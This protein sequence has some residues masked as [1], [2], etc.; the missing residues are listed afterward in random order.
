MNPIV[1]SSLDKTLL[2]ATNLQYLIAFTLAAAKKTAE[3]NTPPAN[4]G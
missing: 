3:P 1:P 4:R 2:L